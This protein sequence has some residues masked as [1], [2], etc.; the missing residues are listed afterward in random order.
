MI[1]LDLTTVAEI[2]GGVLAGGAGTAAAPVTSVTS[3]SRA[4]TSGGLFVALPGERVDG[5][6]FVEAAA[7]AGAVAALT[8][9]AVDVPHVLVPDTTAALADL[10]REVLVRL[11]AAGDL[12]VVAVTGSVGKTT[13]KDLL[14]QLL[15]PCGEVVAPIASYNN[16]IGLPLTVLRATSQTRVLVLEMGADAPGNLTYLTSIAPPDVAVELVVGH[17]HLGG[18]G[19]IEGVAAAKAELVAGLAPGGLAVLNVDDPR[20]AAMAAGAER[21]RTFG[22]SADADVRASDVVM[23]V[24]G[25]ADVTISTSTE[26]EWVRLGLAGEHQ[27]TNALA[28]ATTAMSLGRPLAEVAAGLAQAEPISPH[29]MQ[30]TDTPAGVRVVDDAYNAN[31]TSMRAA[32]TALAAMTAGGRRGIAV[33]GP[34]LDLGAGSAAEHAEIGRVA[35]T[36]GIEEVVTV[37]EQTRPMFDAVRDA[38][39]SATAVPD[40]AEARAL[41]AEMVRPGDVVLVKASNGAG[42]SSL[43]EALATAV[44]S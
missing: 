25:H 32:L 21:V 29:R 1:P 24:D 11:R 43:G 34:M 18:F 6:D 30:V 12:T 17:A 19:S 36:L 16:E 13:T 44:A 41:L 23:G 26:H 2:T 42:L 8:T 9:R 3:D 4:V 38:G 40:A 35:A 39:G 14:A 22:R 5:H 27:V 31:P 15:R 37:G 10:A 7:A 28:A 33:L 20:V